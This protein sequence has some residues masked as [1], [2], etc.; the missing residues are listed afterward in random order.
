MTKIE[1]LREALNTLTNTEAREVVE[2]MIAQLS[3]PH[4]ASRRGS[5][6]TGGEGRSHPAEASD[7]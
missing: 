7:L 6:R 1:A 4:T 5:C 2:K 3:K